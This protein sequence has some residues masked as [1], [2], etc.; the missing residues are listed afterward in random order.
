MTARIA[1]FVT[2]AQAELR[3]P[4]SVSLSITPNKGGVAGHYGGPKQPAAEPGA[5]HTKC[6][7]TWRAWQKYHMDTHGW[8][9]I[10]YTGGFCN[11][12]YAFA[13]RGA[14]VRT[15]ANG[16]N[17]GNQNFYAV[18]WIGGE[19]QVPTQLAINAFEW[20]VAEL[21]KQGAGRAVWPHRKFKPTGCPGDPIVNECRRLDGANVSPQPPS[22]SPTPPP[23]PTPTPAPSKPEETPVPPT[24]REGD[25]GVPVR[26]LQALLVAVHHNLDA[27]GGI[28]GIFGPGLKRELAAFQKARGLAADGVC[29]PNTWKRLILG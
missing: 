20:W 18:T 21:R 1:G 16:T 4:K 8:S 11:H 29:G 17:T 5:D 24:L 3:G 28:D 14:G 15:A 10:A 25:R 7:S 26:R 12:G 22:P 2:R 13:G 23:R 9:D 27:E 6:V 19:G